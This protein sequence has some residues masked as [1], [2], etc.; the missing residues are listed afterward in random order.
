MTILTRDQ[1][2]KP[3][4]RRITTVRLSCGS[5]ARLR[6]ITE[7][8]RADYESGLLD[9]K[10]AIR[11]ERLLSARRRLICLTLVGPDDVPLF[12]INEEAALADQDGRMMEELYQAAAVHCGIKDS[13]V[14]TLVG[15]SRPTPADAGG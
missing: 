8:E 1:L 10:G 5:E 7:R 3:S 12:G 6:S 4:A 9:S 2:L 14:E 15:N 11:K 13:D